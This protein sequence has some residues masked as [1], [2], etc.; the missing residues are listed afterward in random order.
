LLNDPQINERDVRN[1]GKS[2][3]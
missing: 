3:N 1:W 2:R